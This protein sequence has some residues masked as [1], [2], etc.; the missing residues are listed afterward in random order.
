MPSSDFGGYSINVQGIIYSGSVHFNR[1]IRKRFLLTFSVTIRGWW[2]W[3]ADVG[4]NNVPISLCCSFPKLDLNNRAANDSWIDT[5]S[6]SSIQALERFSVTVYHQK[7]K[8]NKKTSKIA[9]KTDNGESFLLYYRRQSAG[10]W[11][12]LHKDVL[13]KII[14]KHF[15]SAMNKRLNIIRVL[16][17]CYNRK[18]RCPPYWMKKKQDDLS[19]WQKNWIHFHDTVF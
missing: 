13:W 4:L 12:F 7:Q 8:P 18:P 17:Y 3:V 9:R 15:T 2:V 14:A 5:L 1:G 6:R 11:L 16:C 10:T 19:E